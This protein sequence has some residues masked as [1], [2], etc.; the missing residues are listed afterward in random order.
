MCAGVS[1][2]VAVL[3]GAFGAHIL[4]PILPLQSMTI[5]ETAVRYQSVHTLALLATALAIHQFPERSR[6]LDRAGFL[7]AA[8]IVLFSGSLYGVA[9]TDLRW[10]GAIA[11]LGGICWVVAWST[12]G[13]TLSRFHKR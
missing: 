9:L 6:A 3:L 8:G 12:L 2:A 10:A 13:W 5:F 4:R 1:G 11:P 7:F